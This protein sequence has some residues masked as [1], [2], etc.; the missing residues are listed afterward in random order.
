MI[1]ILDVN[2]HKK[3]LDAL[4]CR[5]VKHKQTKV[6]HFEDFREFIERINEDYK[7]NIV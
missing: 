6:F 5:I 2:I 3:H 1:K 4:S 7:I